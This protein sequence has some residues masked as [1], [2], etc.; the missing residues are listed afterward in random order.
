MNLVNLSLERRTTQSFSG[1]SVIASII[2][3]ISILDKPE[4]AMILQQNVL[5]N[6]LIYLTNLF[7]LP[8]VQKSFLRFATILLFTFSGAPSPT[9]LPINTYFHPVHCSFSFSFCFH[10]SLLAIVYGAIAKQIYT[11]FSFSGMFTLS[12]THTFLCKLSMHST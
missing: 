9:V 7:L 1:C 6:A 5:N 8:A 4:T 3:Y 12:E 10:F 11:S 2:A